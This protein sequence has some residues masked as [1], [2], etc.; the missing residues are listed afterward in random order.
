MNTLK[1]ALYTISVMVGAILVIWGLFKL[2]NK[3]VE[4]ECGCDQ[5][6]TFKPD[7]IALDKVVIIK[8]DQDE[9]NYFDNYDKVTNIFG[10]PSKVLDSVMTYDTTVI[11]GLLF[12]PNINIVQYWQENSTLMPCKISIDNNAWDLKLKLTE[13]DIIL[14]RYTNVADLKDIFPNS[15]SCLECAP[16][17]YARGVVRHEK[18]KMKLNYTES[19]GTV[20]DII[21]TFT[22]RHLSELIY[23]NKKYK[24]SLHTTK[25]KSNAS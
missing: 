22:D 20:S 21:L 5:W 1:Q 19:D 24:S 12:E 6:D 14:S 11:R 7:I 2:V 25:A 4:Q 8:D 3:P 23:G 13:K 15:Y 16:L 17:G 18:I 9:L 10:P